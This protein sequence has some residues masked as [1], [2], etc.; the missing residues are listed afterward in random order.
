MGAF[1][2]QTTDNPFGSAAAYD[3]EQSM[4]QRYYAEQQ[5]AMMQAYQN[6]LQRAMAQAYQHEL[7]R[8]E[9]SQG[10]TPSPRALVEAA[11]KPDKRLLLCRV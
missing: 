8:E 10:Y 1:I 9:L 6:D 11:P 7:A 2:P 5:R 3:A 4:Q